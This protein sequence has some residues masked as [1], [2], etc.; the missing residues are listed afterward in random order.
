MRKKIKTILSNYYCS[1][2]TAYYLRMCKQ[3][4]SRILNSNDG[5]VKVMTLEQNETR[6]QI[7]NID[8]LYP[9]SEKHR[10]K[11]LISILSFEYRITMS[12]RAGK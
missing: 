6:D 9:F 11:K 4:I 8:K 2:L 7:R 3:S 1:A 12:I 10:I 5:F